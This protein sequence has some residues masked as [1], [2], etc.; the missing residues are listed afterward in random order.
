MPKFKPIT[1]PAA[2]LR[3]GRPPSKI[4]PPKPAPADMPR[5]SGTAVP[6]PLLVTYA[7]AARLLGGVS[8]RYV[9]RLVT[10]GKLKRKGRNKARRIVYQSILDYIAQEGGNG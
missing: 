6:T 5:N 7:E 2:S 8:I 9:E 10:A 3:K 1:P 4:N